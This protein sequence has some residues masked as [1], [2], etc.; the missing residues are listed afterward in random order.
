MIVLYQV[1]RGYRINKSRNYFE[2]KEIEENIAIWKKS[3]KM[4][5]A[6]R[7]SPFNS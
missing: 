5:R 6:L 2:W 7:H 4:F 3:T 1:Y